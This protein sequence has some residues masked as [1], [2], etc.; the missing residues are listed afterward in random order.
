MGKLKP[1]LDQID[2]E[3]KKQ[4]EAGE[5]GRLVEC[6][7]ITRE[8]NQAI[9]SFR[10]VQELISEQIRSTLQRQACLIQGEEISERQ[11]QGL[12]NNPQRGQQMLQEKLLDSPSAE[13]QSY[14]SDIIDKCNDVQ[15]L[16]RVINKRFRT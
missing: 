9:T 5:R 11:L 7:R 12:I 8:A 16:E 4:A 14:V 15:K 1:L 13:L 3:F 2:E 6:G 10:D